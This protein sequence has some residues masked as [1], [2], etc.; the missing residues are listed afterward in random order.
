MKTVFV[1]SPSIGAFDTNMAMADTISKIAVNQGHFPVIGSP[2]LPGQEPL[3]ELQEAQLRL[4][5]EVWLFY[6]GRKLRRDILSDLQRAARAGKPVRLVQPEPVAEPWPLAADVYFA[7]DS[8]GEAP[9]RDDTPI[10]EAVQDGSVQFAAEPVRISGLLLAL[11]QLEGLLEAPL[12]DDWWAKAI[13]ARDDYLLKFGVGPLLD[14]LDSLASREL[15]PL[16]PESWTQELA[17]LKEL[18]AG[19]DWP[20]ELPD[21]DREKLDLVDNN[22]WHKLGYILVVRCDYQRAFP[23]LEKAISGNPG[24]FLAWTDLG[25]CLFQLGYFDLAEDA[26]AAALTLAP[27]H[28]YAW[29]GRGRSLMALKRYS[30]AISAFDTALGCTDDQVSAYVMELR[31]EATE[32]RSHMFN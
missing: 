10:N 7:A 14:V 8:Y 24:N 11:K 26:F 6:D 30:E 13:N 3:D 21:L 27:K 19:W 23:F 17:N 5:D 25:E 31:F 15:L 32:A 28:F 20:T 1:C 22:D 9:N 16:W 4:C 18:W 2:I 29:V 12:P